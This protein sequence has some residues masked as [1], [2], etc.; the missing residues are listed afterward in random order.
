MGGR[1]SKPEFG[2]EDDDS[3]LHLDDVMDV[4]SFKRYYA[5]WLQQGNNRSRKMLVNAQNPITGTVQRAWLLELIEEK[6]TTP[7]ML[8]RW[9]RYFSLELQ[10][11]TTDYVIN[12]APAP[13]PF[14]PLIMRIQTVGYP[15][16]LFTP[17]SEAE[18]YDPPS[19]RW[20]RGVIVGAESYYYVF[21]PLDWDKYVEVMT[22]YRPVELTP[23][24][25]ALRARIMKK[26]THMQRVQI[27]Q[28]EKR[29]KEQALLDVKLKCVK[30]DIP[31]VYIRKNSSR[32]RRIPLIDPFLVEFREML[33]LVGATIF[34]LGRILLGGYAQGSFKHGFWLRLNLVPDADAGGVDA[35]RSADDFKPG[36]LTLTG[37]L[38]SSAAT[39][40]ERIF[41]QGFFP[42]DEAQLAFCEKHILNWRDAPAL[43][44]E[45]R[46]LEWEYRLFT[47]NQF[48]VV[49]MPKGGGLSL[50]QALSHQLFG[51]QDN[52]QFIRRIALEY[53][54]QHK[55]YFVQ[56]V[57]IDFEYYTRVKEMA[58]KDGAY[59]ALADHLDLQAVCEIFDA[60]CEIYSR[61]S[62]DVIFKRVLP[63]NSLYTDLNSSKVKDGRLP[64]IRLS[65]AGG[66]E[67]DSIVYIPQPLPLKALGG[68]VLGHHVSQKRLVFDARRK[69]TA[70]FY[71]ATVP[72]KLYTCYAGY[73]NVRLTWHPPFL[74]MNDFKV[75]FISLI[76]VFFFVFVF[77]ADAQRQPAK[78][79]AS[80][81]QGLRLGGSS[82]PAVRVLRPRHLS[83]APP[84]QR[85]CRAARPPAARH[86]A[87]QVFK[88]PDGRRGR[89]RGD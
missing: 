70:P 67:Y 16:Q 61:F 23:A 5:R 62:A 39:Q 21:R 82:R 78:P 86:Y 89:D 15:V 71:A 65:Y 1:S 44:Y 83:Q 38:E 28:E 58:M 34:D 68:G 60:T 85:P 43:L 54:I 22:E 8:I 56:F 59:S 72:F 18:C 87:L 17:S 84:A 27:L 40:P 77:V 81:L 3:A 64:V 9:G 14:N 31:P 66:D 37:R 46:Q 75:H 19:G 48:R 69:A 42:R 7:R 79:P 57:D 4:P 73:L 10:F 2:E 29:Q 80:D 20:V 45:H 30:A 33:P 52:W 24:Q 50:Y 25:A 36:I 51:S 76:F 47:R 32:L 35:Q 13:E 6:G 49:R 11:A 53:I 74:V 12:V 41:E 55:D 26:A 63:Q 88:G